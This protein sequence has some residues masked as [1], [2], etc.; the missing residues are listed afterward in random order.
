LNLVKDVFPSALNGTLG[1][2]LIVFRNVAIYLKPEIVN[3]I[4][5]RFHDSLRPGGWLLLG[6]TELSMAA[7]PQFEVHRFDR[8]VF[9]RRKRDREEPD[10]RAALR[11]TARAL[12]AT[13][14]PVLPIVQ[15]SLPVSTTSHPPDAGPVSPGKAPSGSAELPTVLAFREHKDLRSSDT[16]LTE[17]ERTIDAIVGQKERATA[18]LKF[19]LQLLSCAEIHRAEEMLEKCLEEEPLLIEAHLLKATLAEEAGNFGEAER[20]YRRAL[21]VDRRCAIAHFHLALVQRERG[22]VRGAGRSLQTVVGLTHNKDP[23]GLVEHSDGVCYG[24]LR[25][26]AEMLL[27]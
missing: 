22:D 26:M 3:A 27:D 21:Y 16:N 14:P 25:E 23:H 15:P 20:G 12:P 10:D 1:L 6:E 18:R 11:V 19:V 4:I 9:H 2:D 17:G 24:R 5:Q 7:V 8:A 13:A